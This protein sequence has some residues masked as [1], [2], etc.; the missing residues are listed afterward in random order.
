[1]V[2]SCAILP[3]H[4]HLVLGP[5]ALR[6]E[7]VVIQLKGEA[8]ALLVEEGL[9]PFGGGS[10]GRP[11]KCFARGQWKV[12]LDA[13]DVPNAIR[14]VEENPEKEGKPRQRWSFVVAPPGSG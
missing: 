2:W 3:D 4:V 14:Y 1:M 6:I 9:H 13:G 8:T 12:Y 11:P 7:Q 5:P 10:G